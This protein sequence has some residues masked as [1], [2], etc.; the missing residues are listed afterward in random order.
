[1]IPAPIHYEID[2]LNID[3]RADG[4][5]AIVER[6]D[7]HRIELDVRCAF[8]LYLF[9]SAQALQGCST[10]QRPDGQS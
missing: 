8:A 5:L 9:F 6:R 3:L 1:M 10:M 7:G 2:D 4:T